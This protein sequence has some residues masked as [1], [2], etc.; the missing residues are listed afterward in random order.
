MYKVFVNEKPL[1]LTNKIEKETNFKIYLLETVN[2]PK[3]ISELF[4]NKIQIAVL[5]FWNMI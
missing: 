3:V 2:I 5:H 1:F 4:L